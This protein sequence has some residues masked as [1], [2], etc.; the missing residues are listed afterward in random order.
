[1][2]VTHKAKMAGYHKNI[3]FRKRVSDEDDEDEASHFQIAGM[4]FQFTLLNQEFE[5]QDV[6]NKID[7]SEIILLDSQ[8]TMDMLCNSSLVA[9]KLKSNSSM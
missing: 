9:E 6:N 3:W 5:S 1:M 8:S 2:S 7:L 4:G